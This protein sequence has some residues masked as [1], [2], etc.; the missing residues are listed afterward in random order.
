MASPEDTKQSDNGS[1]LSGADEAFLDAMNQGKGWRPDATDTLISKAVRVKSIRRRFLTNVLPIMLVPLL[2]VGVLAIVGLGLLGQ[3]TN[4][5]VD[6]TDEILVEHNLNVAEEL[7]ESADSASRAIDS[8]LTGWHNRVSQIENAET[9]VA[10]AA[11]IALGATDVQVVFVAADGSVISST[12]PETTSS[13]YADAEWL[14]RAPEGDLFRSFVDDDEH[15]PSIEFSRGLTDG[16]FVRVR[17]PFTNLHSITERIAERGGVDIAIADRTVNVVIA[18]TFID[19]DPNILYSDAMALG[20]SSVDLTAMDLDF[21]SNDDT[22]RVSATSVALLN[23][24]QV[25]FPFP[26]LD[27][28]AVASEPFDSITTSLLSFSDA[29]EE[30]NQRQRVLTLGIALIGLITAAVAFFALRFA[31]GQITQPVEQLSN[32]AQRAA[33]IGI[34]AVVEAARSTDEL[35]ELDE[36]AVES[37]DELS[38]LAAS[39]NT[40]QGAAVELA[41]GQAQLRRQNVS[42]TFVSLGRRNQNLLNR[43]LEFIEELEAQERDADALENLFKLDHLATRMRRN[44]ENLLVLA[45]EQTPRRWGRPI[46]VR[47]VL[48]AAASEIA[49]YRRVR[50]GEIDEGTISGNLATDLSHLFAEL[51]ENAG[52]FSPPTAPIEVF[53]QQTDTH[54]RLA[55]VDQGIGMDDEALAQVND[56]LENPVDFADAPSAYLGLFVVGRLAQEMGVKVHLAS[57]DQASDGSRRG[58]IAYIE[59]P[60]ALLSQDAA[61]GAQTDEK[62][63]EAVARRTDQVDQGE[64]A[65]DSSA[66]VFNDQASGNDDDSVEDSDDDSVEDAEPAAEPATAETPDAN[67]LGIKDT[68]GEKTDAGFPKRSKGATKVKTTPDKFVSSKPAVAEETAENTAAELGIKDTDGEKTDAGFPKRSK[69]A[70]KVKTSPD[71]FVSSKPAVAEEA[72]QNTAA[73]LGIEETNGEKTDA[74]FPKRSK[75]ATS[76]KSSPDK[77]VSSKP[78]VAEGAS[79][80]PAK[81]R[82][83]KMSAVALV[84]QAK[85][86]ARAAAAKETGASFG[87]AVDKDEA[88]EAPPTIPDR[89]LPLTEAGFPK[90]TSNAEGSNSPLPAPSTEGPAPMR[91]RDADQVKNSLLSYRAAVQRGRSQAENAEMPEAVVATAGVGASVAADG[92]GNTSLSSNSV[93]IEENADRN[94]QP[95]DNDE[96]LPG[97]AQ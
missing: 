67:E 45:G 17:I 19:Q 77:F 85:A 15:T 14:E 71:K 25:E 33:A 18:D 97:S 56:R 22:R 74:G 58:T 72:T 31:A 48:R 37:E 92:G 95:Q 75:G 90:R 5:A 61:S 41:A 54:Y 51:L 43:Q 68:D 63:S 6:A 62:A 87:A 79:D 66:V 84:N 20:D 65:S 96:A 93:P 39:L 88:H 10:T 69:G 4:E 34:P 28:V 12:H 49:D 59:L 3:R 47:D 26:G 73:D 24:E 46:A 38:I 53:G 9:P 23:V 8:F 91:E 89:A 42:R 52:S 94:E 32:Q 55:I 76:I 82:D 50:L 2:I 30:V 44:A 57:A 60:N 27:W 81:K 16:N 29:S 35:P 64:K 7:S 13:S 86:E 80:A 21:S 36:F 40:M 83:P 11:N 78:A 70:T 1:D